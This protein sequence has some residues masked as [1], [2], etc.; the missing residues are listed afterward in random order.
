MMLLCH[1]LALMV[2]SWTS[3]FVLGCLSRRTL[4]LTG[5]LYFLIG[6]YPLLRGVLLLPLYFFANR[7][8]PLVLLM[9]ALQ[10]FLQ[11]I[12]FVFPSIAGVRQGLRKRALTLCQ[13]KLLAPVVVTL[14]VLATWTGGWP[15]AAL[16]RWSGG[17]WDPSVGWLSRLLTFAVASWPVGYLLAVSVSRRQIQTVHPVGGMR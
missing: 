12:L 5:A 3:A 2:W 4:W 15:H 6:A 9:L 1:G 10:M 14:A 16:V 17:V 11:T 7:P 13:M 8:E